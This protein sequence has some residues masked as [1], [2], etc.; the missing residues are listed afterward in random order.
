MCGRKTVVVGLVYA[1]SGVAVL[2]FSLMLT[3]C[4]KDK[5]SD[6]DSGAVTDVRGG[7]ADIETDRASPPDGGVSLDGAKDTSPEVTQG[8]TIGPVDLV[9]DTGPEIP[10]GDLPGGELPESDVQSGDIGPDDTSVEDVSGGNCPIAIIKSAEGDEVIPQTV[11]HLYG[12]ESYKQ[13]GEISKYEWDV[14]QPAGSQSVFIPSYL[15]PNP[16]FETNVAGVYDFYLT[17]YDQTDTPSCLP[18]T[19]KV[20][21]IPDEAI[22]IE[23]LWHTP[24]DPDESDTG[25]EAG[26]DLDLHFVHPLA[27]GP[28]LIGDGKPDQWFDIPFDC[29]WF[30][31]HPNWGS[32]EPTI[33]DDPGLDRDDTDGAGP[34]NINLDIPEDTT[35]RVGVHYWNDHGWGASFTTVRVYI[36]AQ[37]VFEVADVMLVDSDMWDVCTIT[38][39]SG[40]VKVVVDDVGQYK[41]TPDYHNPY[42]FQ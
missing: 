35:Y 26:A 12:D 39:P 9:E 22:H 10:G 28:D 38:W 23:L 29:F 2:S 36:Y 16:S 41:I 5:E 6:V 7:L 24:D 34:E 40:S 33:N 15:F 4:D 42:F 13:G 3:S 32:Y 20:V 30:N 37:L 31:A 17:V 8:E 14:D 21:V 18:A 1:L 25:P 27:V 19:Y 11:L